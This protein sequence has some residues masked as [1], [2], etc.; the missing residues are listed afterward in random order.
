GVLLDQGR[1]L[2]EHA[3]ALL[4]RRTRP[5]AGLEG[6]A[7]TGDGAIDVLGVARG[8]ARD[9]AAA[10]GADAVERLAGGGVDVVAV[11]EGLRADG[12]RADDVFD[13]LGHDAPPASSGS[14]ITSVR[15]PSPRRSRSSA[16]WTPPRSVVCVTTLTRS[17]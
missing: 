3:L 11:D 7:G 12:E 16:S 17:R 2:L 10:R 8:D 5:G 4:R 15:E 13:G 9:D 14:T 1:E 6:T